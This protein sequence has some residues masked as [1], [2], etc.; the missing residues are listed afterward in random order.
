M[1]GNISINNEIDFS[2]NYVV[3]FTV[4]YEVEINDLP[5]KAPETNTKK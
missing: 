2:I 1:T 4:D 5:E 3:D